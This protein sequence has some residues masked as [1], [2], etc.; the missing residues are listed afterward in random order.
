MKLT[1]GMIVLVT[2]GAKML[3]LKNEGDAINPELAVIS[4]RAIDN[5]PNRD[6]RSDAPGVAFSSMGH[7]RSTYEEADPHQ[8]AE[9]DFTA[10][11]AAAL[12]QVVQE[13][14][15]KVVVVA[16]PATLSVLRRHYDRATQE[17]LVAE[18]DKDL[19][20]HPVRDITRLISELDR[21][22]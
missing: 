12:A 4:Q 16:P 13:N 5:P 18:I 21:P 2:D 20:R 6:Q 17:R 10:G 14:D 11:S 7:R 22:A 19:T 1:A 9:D 15:G 3:L 8:R